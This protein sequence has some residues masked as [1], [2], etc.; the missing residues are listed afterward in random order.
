MWSDVLRHL[1]K[2]VEARGGSVPDNV[3]PLH[4]P[5]VRQATLVR[6]DVQHTFD[7]FV[8]EIGAWWP[9]R[10]Y[11]LGQEKVS[12]VA[13]EPRVGGRVYETWSDGTEVAWGELLAW[14]PPAGFTMTWTSLPEVTEVELRFRALGPALTRVELEHRGWERLTEE[15]LAAATRVGG[16]YSA[17]WAQILDLFRQH[18]GSG[19]PD[20]DRDRARDDT[21]G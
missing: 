13:V 21:D 14:D 18:V 11:S 12:A 17:G 16:G 10:P 20:E 6:S 7:V 1:R 5:P 9:I 2:A 4:R 3:R 19:L 8:R 15:Q